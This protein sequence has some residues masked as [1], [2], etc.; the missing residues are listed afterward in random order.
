M[1]HRTSLGNG[2]YVELDDIGIKI[3]T[4]SGFVVTNTILLEPENYAALVD[5]V[6]RSLELSEATAVAA[7]QAIEAEP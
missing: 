1:S 3:T 5:F 7:K 4:M 2:I 6:A